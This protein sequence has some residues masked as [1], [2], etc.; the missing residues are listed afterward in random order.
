LAWAVFLACGIL[1]LD[2]GWAEAEEV[3]DSWYGPAHYGMPT[4]SGESYEPSSYTAPRKPS[5]TATELEVSYEGRPGPA[6][7]G[8]AGRP[9]SVADASPKAKQA[10]GLVGYGTGSPNH[11]RNGSVAAP[12][13]TRGEANREMLD[14]PDGLPQKELSQNDLP[15]DELLP[16]GA[17]HGVEPS[18]MVLYGAYNPDLVPQPDEIG[19][20]IPSLVQS[21]GID[22]GFIG[23]QEGFRLD[24]YVPNPGFSRSGVTV[25][26]GV[27]IGQRSVADIQALDIPEALKQKLIPYAGLIGQDAIN[28]LANYPLYVTED[29]AYA[30][31][32]AVAQD[33]FGEVATLYDAATTGD[34]F[35]ELPPEARTAIADVAYQYGPHLAQQLPNFW[36]DVTQGRWEE[37]T[38]AL[39]ELGDRYP[40]RRNAEANLLEQAM[41][42][43]EAASYLVQ[44]GDTLSSIASRLGTSTQYLAARNGLANLDVI[45]S[46]QILYY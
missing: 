28:F 34:S 4:A 1:V 39:R 26:M 13:T 25:G 14:T 16:D 29:E 32:Q 45:Y 42:I 11:P 24:A 22:T 31:D 17:T 27:D 2:T 21:Y 36:S 15:Q 3:L 44:P 33:I 5:P 23:S 20:S 10:N 41:G 7:D 35:L 12:G 37:A 38:Q 30:L 43:G 46:G 18:D 19:S 6:A 9:V 8:Q 40:A